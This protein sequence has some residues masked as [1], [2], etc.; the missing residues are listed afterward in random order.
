MEKRAEIRVVE[1]PARENH[2]G[3]CFVRVKLHWR[4]PVCG[5]PRG[6]IRRVRSYDGRQ[7]LDCDGWANPCGHVDK[8]TDVRKEAAENGL[9]G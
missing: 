9:N 6:E 4:C 2:M 3:L 5:K 8:Y 1:I 7:Y